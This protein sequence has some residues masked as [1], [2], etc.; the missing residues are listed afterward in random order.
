[1]LNLFSGDD[2]VTDGVGRE[3]VTETQGNLF[4]V[5]QNFTRRLT[6]KDSAKTLRC[7]ANHPANDM[8]PLSTTKQISIVCKYEKNY[9]SLLTY[10]LNIKNGHHW[11]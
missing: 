6:W 7:E 4:T 9:V 3:E 5:S 2:Q 11:I 10:V 8:R 1:M